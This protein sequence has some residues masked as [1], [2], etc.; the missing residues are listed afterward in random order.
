[1]LVDKF[2]LAMRN[3]FSIHSRFL[4]FFSFFFFLRRIIYSRSSVDPKFVIRKH[5]FLE[6]LRTKEKVG[7]ESRYLEKCSPPKLITY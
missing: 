6:E 3:I 4:F 1:M 7:L 5:V 2:L